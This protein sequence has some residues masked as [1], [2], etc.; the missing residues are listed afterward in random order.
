MIPPFDK[1]PWIVGVTPS[2]NVQ[3]RVREGDGFVDYW[4]PPDPAN[5]DYQ[6]YLRWR[7][8]GNSPALVG[9]WSV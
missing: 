6:E 5:T 1:T 9:D 2:G 7:A 4:V 8:E 3:I